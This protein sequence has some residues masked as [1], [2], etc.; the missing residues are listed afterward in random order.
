MFSNN[1]DVTD[2]LLNPGEPEKHDHANETKK[3][4]D[5]KSGDQS[6]SPNSKLSKLKTYFSRKNS[7]K[8]ELKLIELS[9]LKDFLFLSLCVAT[10][11]Y[12]MSLF[13]TLV[14]VPPLAKSKGISDAGASW[15]VSIMGLSDTTARIISGFI[16]D[17]SS[18]KPHRLLVYNFVLYGLGIISMIVPMVSSFQGYSVIAVTYGV[19]MGCYTSQKT[20]IVVDVIGVEK[21][22]ASF[23]LLLLFQGVG[24]LIGPTFSGKVYRIFKILYYFHPATVL[25]IC[26]SQ[27]TLPN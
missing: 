18:V 2:S 8:K 25:Y 1:H 23:G 11:T 24:S 3:Y 19:L 26:L 17:L 12:T 7:S 6:S 27:T 14:F 9:L 4:A 15:I 10:F 5:I 16:F 22:A 21:M 13:I 20:V